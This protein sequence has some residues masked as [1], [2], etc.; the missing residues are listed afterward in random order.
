MGGGLPDWNGVRLS[1]WQVEVFCGTRRIQKRP[2]ILVLGHKKVWRR[3]RPREAE[4]GLILSGKMRRG[5][6]TETRE[7]RAKGTRALKGT[8]SVT[9][10]PEYYR[11]PV[12]L[13]KC[14]CASGRGRRSG[15]Q[16]RRNIERKPCLATAREGPHTWPGWAEYCCRRQTVEKSVRALDSQWPLLTPG[17]LFQLANELFTWQQSYCQFARKKL[18]F[19]FLFEISSFN[20]DKPVDCSDDFCV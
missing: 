5:G 14:H 4:K 11:Q 15:E 16:T 2:K 7:Q 6:G 18:F 12:G 10:G 17:N 1:V 19:G 3:G 8:R 13:T 20:R 9:A